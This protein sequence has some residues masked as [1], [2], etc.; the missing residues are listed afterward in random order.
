MRQHGEE[1][2]I[3]TEI[4]SVE[5]EIQTVMWGRGSEEELEDDNEEKQQIERQIETDR[6]EEGEQEEIETKGEAEIAG[7]EKEESEAIKRKRGR[8][9]GKD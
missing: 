2:E 5:A 3:K 8:V 9:E 4:K 1:E 7:E 6:K